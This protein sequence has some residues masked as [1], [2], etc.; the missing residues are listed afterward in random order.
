MSKSR[1]ELVE[2]ASKALN[3]LNKSD[4][5]NKVIPESDSELS[6]YAGGK[7]EFIV[8]DDCFGRMDPQYGT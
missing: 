7:Y 4:M 2:R 1:N 6:R 8:G 5:C 3:I